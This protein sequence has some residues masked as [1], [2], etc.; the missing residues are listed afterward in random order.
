MPELTFNFNNQA[1]LSL[2]IDAQCEKH[3]YDMYKMKD[4]TKAQFAKR[5]EYKNNLSKQAASAQNTE[6]VEN[7]VTIT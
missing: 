7:N 6:D 1:A 5:M 2:V 4:E 3:S